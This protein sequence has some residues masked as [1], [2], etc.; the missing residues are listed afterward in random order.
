MKIIVAF[1][2]V[3]SFENILLKA[4]DYFTVNIVTCRTF[5]GQRL[6]KHVPAETDSG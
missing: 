2:T 6:G 1:L 5:A 3:F 4:T